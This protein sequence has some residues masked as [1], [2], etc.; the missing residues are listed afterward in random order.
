MDPLSLEERTEKTVDTATNNQITQEIRRSLSSLHQQDDSQRQCDQLAN[1]TLA[2]KQIPFLQSIQMSYE[3]TAETPLKMKR[4]R[5]RPRKVK[6]SEDGPV[7]DLC[8]R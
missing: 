4:K 8:N 2:A 5:G 3:T 1:A 7:T 6:T